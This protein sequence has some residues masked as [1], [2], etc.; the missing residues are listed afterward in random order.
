M[1]LRTLVKLCVL[2]LLL[3]SVSSLDLRNVKHVND[4]SP[5]ET[6][7][8]PVSS[9]RYVS[10]SDP[11]SLCPDE[12]ERVDC[13]YVYLRLYARLRKQVELEVSNFRYV[14]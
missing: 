12:M 2:N 10:G 1:C 8:P 11:W 4:W 7:D 13:F 5:R 3:K 9:K 6:N 14:I